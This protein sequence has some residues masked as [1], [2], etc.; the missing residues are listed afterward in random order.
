[1]D[2]G[3]IFTDLLQR[4]GGYV[5]HPA[6]RGGPTNMGITLATLRTYRAK[7]LGTPGDETT[8]ADVQALTED[9]ARQIYGILYIQEPGFIP[10]NIPDEAVR[11]A[12]IDEGVNSGPGT[13]M[14]H[15]QQ[16]V[17][18]TAD[19][20]WGPVTRAAVANANPQRLL[21]DLARLRLHRYARICQADATQLVFFAG[22]VDRALKFL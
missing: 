9:E 8:A 1:M 3:G 17:G 11:V 10:D 13:A 20:L 2:V 16:A 14:K 22:W 19:G 4:E 6:D 18:V 21:V 7:Y 15:L 12:V 5:D